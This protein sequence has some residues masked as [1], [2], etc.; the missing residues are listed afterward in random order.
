MKIF[1]SQNLTITEAPERLVR[2]IE[3]RLT[4]P[5]PAYE[6]AVRM[7][8]W[9]GNLQTTHL[10]QWD[11]GTL[12]ILTVHGKTTNIMTGIA[13]QKQPGLHTRAPPLIENRITTVG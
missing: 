13:E 8:R 11:T 12:S 10:L 9:T 5:N 3:S 1:L 7:G 4:I 2:E 6:E